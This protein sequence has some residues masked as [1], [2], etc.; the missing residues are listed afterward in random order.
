[1]RI[2]IEVLPEPE[3]QFGKGVTGWEPKK[4][5]VKGG[6]LFESTEIQ[7]IR[8]GLV[9][10][11]EEVQSVRSW[12][13][14]MEGLI[15]S[16]ETNARRFQ[17]F[18]GS[19][20]V[21]NCRYE[22]PDQFLRCIDADSYS[23]CAALP[24]HE[25]FQQFLDLFSSRVEALF[26]DVRPDC[27]LVCLPEELAV[28]RISNPKL[29]YQE[30]IVLERLQK[31]ED[32]E[33][34]ALFAPSPE[35]LRLATELR[36]Q[37]EELLFRNFYRA[38][39]ARCMNHHN[40]V[41]IQVLRRQT[42]IPSEALQSD[43]TRAWNLSVSLYYKSGHFPWRPYDLTPRSC[44]VGI[45]FHHLKRRA[46]DLIYASL[47]QAFSNDVEP[48]A[49]QGGS[50][51]QNQTRNRQPYLTEEQAAEL[52]HR[53]ILA[54]EDRTGSRPS[55]VIV[56]KTS[57]YQQEEEVGFRESLLAEVAACELV[58]FT[59]TGFRLLRRGMHEPWRG[60]LCTVGDNQ[61]YLFT[62]GF[63]P[64]WNE[65]PGPHI[66]AP[67]QIGVAGKTDIRE[68][69]R[70]VLALTK[71]NWN[72]ADGMARNPITI[73]FARKVGTIMTEMPDDAVPNPLYRFYM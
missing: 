13:H 30:R 34:L 50:I 36:P 44:F 21:F 38:L 55:R 49:L 48:F 7:T 60:T 57:R 24:P 28:L 11:S 71:M 10:L 27:V 58:W 18:P 16:S 2:R 65:Y 8:L 52:M 20:Q 43:A 53:V 12:F 63:V 25:R 51:P 22:L 17:E 66:P 37:A 40:P 61:H 23:R 1:V 64:A 69:A 3:L 29:S 35:E 33:Q 6:P 62:T 68:R 5:L 26:G 47:A 59:P 4:A 41:P 73:S 42:Y 46:G 56:H 15:L 32:D 45:S 70:E 54:Y 72:N 31:E 67:L 14:R 19:R 39:K 9:A